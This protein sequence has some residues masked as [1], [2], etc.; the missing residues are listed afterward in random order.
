MKISF[1][2]HGAQFF[3]CW[4]YR[5]TRVYTSFIGRVSFTVKH[6][7]SALVQWIDEISKQTFTSLHKYGRDRV[8]QSK[9]LKGQ[10]LGLTGG[11]TLHDR[12][13]R[14]SLNIERR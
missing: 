9:I 11:R 8:D 13:A 10:N 7:F 4:C 6:R 12:S 1:S 5:A 3:V 14:M 2:E